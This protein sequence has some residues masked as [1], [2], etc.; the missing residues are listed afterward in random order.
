MPSRWKSHFKWIMRI[1]I[2]MLNSMSSNDLFSDLVNQVTVILQTKT[3]PANKLI[4]NRSL[5]FHASTFRAKDS[6]N[7][8]HQILS[9]LS[10]LV[11][12]PFS[13]QAVGCEEPI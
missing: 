13:R 3:Q 9:V 11:W 7:C 5:L 10:V 12:R 6:L 2:V 4:R 1:H 8:S